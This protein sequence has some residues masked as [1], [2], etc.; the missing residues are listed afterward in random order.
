MG[1]G[2][3]LTT[4]NPYSIN[5]LSKQKKMKIA[6]K[7]S[8]RTDRTRE[9]IRTPTTAI[10]TA[11]TIGLESFSPYFAAFMMRYPIKVGNPTIKIIPSKLTT[12]PI[13][14]TM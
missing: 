13:I 6:L 10:I 2:T 8:V 4:G 11:P 9:A 14:S 12:V 1:D 7:P 5:F 3:L